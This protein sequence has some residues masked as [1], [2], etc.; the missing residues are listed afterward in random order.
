MFF[1]ATFVLF[2]SF[3]LFGLTALAQPWVQPEDNMLALVSQVLPTYLHS[4]LM[5]MPYN[6][7]AQK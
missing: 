7:Y 5:C 2:I 6:L 4:S 1:R 3:L